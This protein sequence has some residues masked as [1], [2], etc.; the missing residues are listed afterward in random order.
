M[1]MIIKGKIWWIEREIRS[2]QMRKQFPDRFQNSEPMAN[3]V[4]DHLIS[5]LNEKKRLLKQ[6]L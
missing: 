5:D 4:I 1:N 2:L 3:N 6:E